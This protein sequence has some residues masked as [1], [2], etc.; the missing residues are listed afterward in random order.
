MLN[1]ALDSLILSASGWR[2]VF[3]PDGEH[4]GGTHLLP[5]NRSIAMG[6]GIVWGQWLIN[7]C[8][9][10]PAV[11]VATDTRPTGPILAEIIMNGLESLGCQIRYA[12]IAPAPEIMARSAR[13][14]DIDGF[15]YIS[16]SHNPLGY[17][18]VK[19]G[20]GGG[21]LGGNE[22][23]ELISNYRKVMIGHLPLPVDAIP[24]KA[25]PKEKQLCCKIYRKLLEETARGRD[26]SSSM[27]L[28]ALRTELKENP[29]TIL[30]DLNGSARCTS[31]DKEFLE[32]LGAEFQGMN[33]KAGHIVHA[34]LPEGESLEP[35]RIALEKA[36]AGNSN[37]LA[38]YVTDNDGDRG[39]LVIW[40]E[41]QDRARCLEAQEVFALTALAELASLFWQIGE[42]TAP[43]AI[44]V[45][46]PTSHRV[47][48]IASVYGVDVFE[49]EVG[50]ANVVNRGIELR[51][52]GYTVR[53]LGEGS[54]G[55]SITHPSEVR[56]PLNMIT[57][58][59]K[60]LRLPGPFEDWCRRIGRPEVGRSG[61]TPANIIATLP[62]FT[63]TP[64][65][66]ERAKMTIKTHNH[67]EL[68]AAWEE[69]FKRQWSLEKNKLEEEFGFTDW[70]E[71]NNEG[72]KSRIGSG[73]GERSGEER[74]GLKVVFKDR[75][76]D[77]AGF[78]WMR[79]SGTEPVFR[80]MAEIRGKNRS[81]EQKLLKW[82]RSMVADADEACIM[83]QNM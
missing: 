35:C 57:A 45:N 68:K 22:A 76:G 19:F 44:V 1:N 78:L 40:D 62:S 25:N 11:L 39:N 15:A 47:R 27:I 20:T 14:K 30:A 80:V 79:G 52:E 66:A 65:S 72:T 29:I 75:N 3:A 69:I 63:T 55:G 41:A 77:D 67:G 82:L 42:T 46:G 12:G 28:T 33:T 43:H 6:M 38:G 70:I 21:V 24:R 64:V 32:S 83:K 37:A 18:G 48:C 58:L 36:H 5:E 73:T 56:D 59:L 60:L 51:E 4:G 8:K 17:N 81:K 54:N 61:F 10:T 49:T 71:I 23:Q 13:D 7:H 74:G 31:V 2:K 26:N 53:F 50:E 9:A 34:I 16:A